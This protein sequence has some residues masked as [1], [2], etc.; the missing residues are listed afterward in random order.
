MKRKTETKK[1]NYGENFPVQPS[2]GNAVLKMPRNDVKGLEFP[3]NNLILQNDNLNFFEKTGSL[4][5]KCFLPLC[6]ISVGDD[7][8][9]RA[10]F[11]FF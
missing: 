6:L 9:S 4:A 7:L 10:N 8:R 2:A 3:L 5:R 11:A 1:T